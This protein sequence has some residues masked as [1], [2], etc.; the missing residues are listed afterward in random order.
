MNEL[1]AETIE[2]LE[3]LEREATPGPWI[4]YCYEGQARDGGPHRYSLCREPDGPAGDSDQH[5][6]VATI[7]AATE[8]AASITAHLLAEFRNALPG[9]LSQAKLSAER[10]ERIRE[11][12]KARDRLVRDAAHAKQLLGT[13]L[14][15]LQELGE[16]SFDLAQKPP[17]PP[18]SVQ[19]DSAMP[20]PLPEVL[21]AGTPV[22]GIFGGYSPTRFEARLSGRLYELPNELQPGY[23][24][25]FLPSSV[26]WSHWR[27]SQPQTDPPAT[28]TLDVFVCPM[29]GPMVRADQDGCCATCGAD[30]KVEPRP[31]TVAPGMEVKT[32]SAG[33]EVRDGERSAPAAT[34]E[35]TDSG[36][37]LSPP[38][39]FGKPMQ[40]VS[41]EGAELQRWALG[42]YELERFHGQSRWRWGY[43]SWGSMIPEP[44]AIAGIE[45]HARHLFGWLA[46]LMTSAVARGE[47]GEDYLL[48]CPACGHTESVPFAP[49]DACP[50][51]QTPM[52][53]VARGEGWEDEAALC[54][55][56]LLACEPYE[57]RERQRIMIEALEKARAEGA[58]ETKLITG[59]LRLLGK[60]ERAI[61]MINAERPAETKAE[62]SEGEA[63]TRAT[64]RVIGRRNLHREANAVAETQALVLEQAFR[65]LFATL[66]KGTKER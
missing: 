56:Q 53:E 11:L 45:A 55:G 30:S 54:L 62:E 58:A 41:E 19:D 22:W 1:P 36:G 48:R 40:L 47:G 6:C 27:A 63:K 23:K 28:R 65:A 43:G 33:S 66:P 24:V 60:V 8:E 59:V 25:H 15:R 16:S 2:E 5:K 14:G 3:R 64:D 10:G 18:P 31:V 29:C 32:M 44:R 7:F 57:T 38:L 20:E 35:T 21:P 51:C 12:E 9:L 39:L 61:D 37:H 52:K 17:A 13:A 34:P 46:P 42:F 49:G 4:A 26:N 50:M